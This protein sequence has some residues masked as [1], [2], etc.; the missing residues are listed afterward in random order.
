MYADDIIL[1]SSSLPI[2]DL[3]EMINICTQSFSQLDLKIYKSKSSCIKIGPTCK[4][5]PCLVKIGST[6]IPWDNKFTYLG[7]SFLA[8]KSLICDLHLLK[9]IFFGALHQN[10]H[11]TI[12]HF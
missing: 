5:T 7:L 1:L 10:I 8:G 2:Y 4:I 9:V 6:P 11:Q 3:Q 12:P